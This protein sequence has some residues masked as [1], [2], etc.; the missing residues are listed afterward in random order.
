M[1]TVL[2]VWRA[3]RGLQRDSGTCALA[4]G[5]VRHETITVSQMAF[6]L[7]LATA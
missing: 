1:E 3:F 2:I 7:L 5:L 6:V 4:V